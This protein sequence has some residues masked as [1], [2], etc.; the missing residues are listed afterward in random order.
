ML[1]KRIVFLCATCPRPYKLISLNQ[2]QVNGTATIH[3]LA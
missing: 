2:I 1:K 3:I